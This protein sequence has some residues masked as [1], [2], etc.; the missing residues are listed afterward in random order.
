MISGQLLPFLNFRNFWKFINRDR[1]IAPSPGRLPPIPT[2]SPWVRVRLGVNLPEG[3]NFPCTFINRIQCQLKQNSL[4][5]YEYF[6]SY[7]VFHLKLRL[8]IK[9]SRCNAFTPDT[10]FD[11]YL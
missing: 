9:A 8:T 2:N 4:N 11:M 10:F 1:K 7:T 6:Q 5:S 3:G